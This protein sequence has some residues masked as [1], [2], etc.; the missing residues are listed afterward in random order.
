MISIIIPT[1]NRINSLER[2]IRSVQVQTHDDWE[3]VI[4]DDGSTDDTEVKIQPFLEDPRIQYYYQS[5]QGVGAARNLGIKKAQG[6]YILFLDSDDSLENNVIES[7]ELFGYTNFDLINW[8]TYKIN[9]EGRKKVTP[10]NLGPLYNYNKL[11]FLAGSICYKKILLN[12]VGGYDPNLKFGENYE[13]G[14]RI[15]QNPNLSILYIPQAFANYFQFNEKRTSNSL[16]NRLEA[17][18]YEFKKHQKIYDNYKEEKSNVLYRIGYLYQHTNNK[19][20]A[21]EFYRDA[22]KNHLLNIKAWLRL[23]QIE[24]FGS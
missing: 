10:Q 24:I 15:C 16:T 2:S 3:L 21:K 19:K 12:R 7:L 14:L 1:Y 11:T 9:E 13:L 5:N 18:L 20:L 4:I 17:N 22:I 8:D 6:E 23:V